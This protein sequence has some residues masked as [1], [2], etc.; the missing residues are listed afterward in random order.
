MSDRDSDLAT[1]PDWFVALIGGTFPDHGGELTVKGH[2][3]RNVRGIL[4]SLDEESDSQEQT[5]TAFGYKWNQ[6]G[7]F[8]GE[9]V[10]TKARQWIVERYGDVSKADWWDDYGERPLLLDAGC[11]AAYSALALLEERIPSVNYVGVDISNA[12]DV[13]ADRFAERNLPGAFLQASL[14]ELPFPE[15]S[16]DVILSEGVLHHTD[17]TEEA[18]MAVARLL[19]RRGRLM[20]YVYRRKG[21]LREFTDD[22]IRRRIQSLSPDEAWEA[23]RPLTLLGKALGELEVEV[24]VPEEIALLDIPAGPIDVQRLFYW[25]VA[26]AY[27]DPDMSIEEMNH[28]NFDWYAPRNAHRQTLEEVRQ[29]CSN[30]GL[31]IEREDEQDAGITIIAR[32]DS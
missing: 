26:K 30:A 4:R 24:E 25:H 7:T 9:R 22:M 1:A 27:Y 28:I 10:T 17:S 14:T 13:A 32:R 6:R 11:G 8:E 23:M 31:S 29:W 18:L 19:R 16:F 3:Y 21:P 2:S 20:F 5:A 12:V 15:E